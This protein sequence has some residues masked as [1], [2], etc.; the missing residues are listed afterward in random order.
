M[1]GA[2]L[3]IPNPATAVWWRWWLLAGLCL[4]VA[5]F[6]QIAV[7]YANDYSDGV[8]GTDA[9]R[10]GSAPAR[11][12]ASGVSPRSILVAA[13]ISAAVACVAGLV[14][15]VMTAA[16]WLLVVGVLCLLAAWFYTGG[17]YPYGY[18][19]LGE[20][21]VFIFFGLVAVL[22]TQFV[23][24]GR[25]DLLGFLA[26]WA[27]GLGAVMVMMVNNIRD[28]AD[29]EAAG[30]KTLVVRLGEKASR[31]LFDLVGIG[32]VIAV[33]GVGILA[34]STSGIVM[35]A[36][37]LVMV[38]VDISMVRHRLYGLALRITAWTCLVAAIA[39]VFVGLSS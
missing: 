23:L 32:T 24:L 7:N 1:S 11:L 6:L 21:G 4:V 31:V 22:G 15:I 27:Q 26:A 34:G 39:I 8:H 16:Y 38:A 19:G 17:K 36:S 37:V 35:T 33:L 25:V 28:R 5:A 20:L 2:A 30:K 9:H 13:G 29:D 14:V 12:T 10:V 3:A 18:A